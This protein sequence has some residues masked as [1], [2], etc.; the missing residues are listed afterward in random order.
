VKK[1]S[2]GANVIISTV[3]AEA[4][5]AIWRE[6]PHQANFAIKSTLVGFM[7]TFLKI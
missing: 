7:G 6:R 1:G 3:V 5:L 2:G 4:V